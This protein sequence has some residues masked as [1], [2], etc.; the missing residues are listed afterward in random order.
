MKE[1]Y[2]RDSSIDTGAI[3]QVGC[4][5]PDTTANAL[6]SEVAEPAAVPACDRQCR[7]RHPLGACAVRLSTTRHSQHRQHWAAIAAI[8]AIGA[9]WARQQQ[10]G[11]ARIPP[12]AITMY[13]R[14]AKME[15][16]PARRG[17]RFPF[18]LRSS[19]V[20]SH[21]R[22]AAASRRSAMLRWRRPAR[23]A[24]ASP[25]ASV[26]SRKDGVW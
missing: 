22:G 24:A 4:R 17:D 26:R 18:S 15:R 23:A 21:E 5:R 3:W 14:M 2:D 6:G 7:H 8:A 13:P 11:A 20:N 1:R 10:L 12:P 9:V 19:L 16:R 25:V